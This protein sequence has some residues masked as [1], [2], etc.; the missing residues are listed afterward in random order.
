[1]FSLLKCRLRDHRRNRKKINP[2]R[3]VA[4][5]FG[6]IILAGTL[7]LM[8]PISSRSGMGTD[9]ITSLFTATSATCVTGLV[10]VDTWLH[11]SIFGQVVILCLIQLGG[12][13]FMTILTLFSFLLHR[14]IGLSERLIIV[15]TL[16]LNDMDGVVR[17]VQHV[18]IGTA[19]FEGAGTLLLA[20]RFVPRY[21]WAGG[22]WRSLFHAISA[23][24]N[25][26]FDLLGRPGQPFIGMSEYAGDPL[27]LF[28]VI[29]L[30]IAG[31]LGFFVWEDVWRNRSFHNLRL[32]SKMALVTTAVLVVGGAAYFF[33]AEYSNA[34]TLG[35]MPVWEKLINA[36]FQSVTLRT[37]GFNTINQ[38]SLR[39]SSMALSV[40]FMLIGGS[41]GS[42]AGGIKTVTVFILLL[43][44][45][46]GLRGSD[47]VTFHGRA[48][49]NRRAMN[50]VTLSLMVTCMFMLGSMTLSLVDGIPF[51]RAAFETASAMGTVGLT[52]D[53]TCSLGQFSRVVL[54][55]L[56]Y[57]GRVGILSFS[58]AF[59]TRG[60]YQTKI[61]YPTFDIMIG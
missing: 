24:C 19:F 61:K 10:L 7:L 12:L 39:D 48:I 53:V 43:T 11:W 15:S 32:Y 26:G 45:H 59:L 35:G 47:E 8:L 33:F 25:A 4:E 22:L 23:F 38:A 21:G 40:V 5:S 37:A 2:T 20:I 13:G 27:V 55:V 58:L 28:T 9:F 29:T 44:L 46:A 49:P 52:A 17:M 54:I 36:L 50:A 30:I 31:G 1:M 41:S 42:T 51:L 18:L 14:R 57:T 3:V 6:A 56:M 16:N 34:G 60:R